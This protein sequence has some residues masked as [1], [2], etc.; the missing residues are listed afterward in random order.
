MRSDAPPLLPILR[1]RAQGEVLASLLVDPDHEWTI[2]DLSR[3]LSMP[4]T[5]A[6]SEIAR[7]ETGGLVRSRKVGR[8]RLVRPETDNPIIGPLTQLILLTFGPRPVVTEEFADLGADRVLIFG[9]WAARLDGEPG[10]APGDIDVLVVGG[11]VDREALYAA[12]ERAEKRLNRPVNPVLRSTAAWADPKADPLLDEVLRG[13]VVDVTTPPMGSR[14][15]D[16]AEGPRKGP[17]AAR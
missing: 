12:A 4:L 9:S 8:A 11:T 15:R 10:A 5:S 16:V 2:S 7:L 17:T 14:P 6:Q 1:S 3:S 13:P